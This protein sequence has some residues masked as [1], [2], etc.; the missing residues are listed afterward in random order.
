MDPED[1]IEAAMRGVR[2]IV[3]L[4]CNGLGETLEGPCPECRGCGE[5]TINELEVADERD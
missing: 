5:S 3:C 2:I 1:L 4:D